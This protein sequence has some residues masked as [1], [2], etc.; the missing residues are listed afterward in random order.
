MR[1]TPFVPG[2]SRVIVCEGFQD[3]GLICALLGHLKITNCDV[4]FPKKRR[5]GANGETGIPQMVSLLAPFDLDGVAI[6]RDADE[7]PVDSFSKAVAAFGSYPAPQTPFTIHRGKV[8]TGVFLIPGKGRTGTLEDILLDA[9]AISH[10]T[11]LTCIEEFRNCTAPARPWNHNKIVKMKMACAIAAF[12]K[13]DP[14][15][16]LGFIW[17]K[18]AHNPLDINSTAFSGLATFLTEFST[19]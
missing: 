1:E 14:C 18:E 4:A 17:Q 12:C 13:K 7:D 2:G 19:A 8:N 6:I 10:P 11:L 15:C 5:D 9:I 16:S 3:S